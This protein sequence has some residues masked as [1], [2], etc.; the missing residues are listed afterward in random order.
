MLYHNLATASVNYGDSHDFQFNSVKGIEVTF[1]SISTALINIL[2]I[3]YTNVI[4]V[5]Y[6]PGVWGL[7]NPHC[8]SSRT[9]GLDK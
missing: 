8:L 3:N 4:D 6:H 1:C 9:R 5:F 2:S 7:S